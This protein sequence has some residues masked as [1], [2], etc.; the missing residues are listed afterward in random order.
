MLVACAVL[1]SPDGYSAHTKAPCTLGDVWECL[2]KAAKRKPCSLG[3][4]YPLSRR[5]VRSLSSGWSGSKLD[6]GP[7]KRAIGNNIRFKSLARPISSQQP[8]GTIVIDPLHHYHGSSRSNQVNELG[9][10][11]RM[12]APAVYR[13][14]ILHMDMSVGLDNGPRRLARDGFEGYRF[15]TRYHS[16]TPASE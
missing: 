11:F 13:A 12:Q 5:H 8:A 2:G 10:F 7:L 9:R 14:R 6:P 3:G 4:Y 16:I 1:V 15:R